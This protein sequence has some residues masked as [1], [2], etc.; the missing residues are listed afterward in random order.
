MENFILSIGKSYTIIPHIISIIS[1]SF[2]YNKTQII[3]SLINMIYN[4]HHMSHLPI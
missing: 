1:F 3:I 4:Y 2:K